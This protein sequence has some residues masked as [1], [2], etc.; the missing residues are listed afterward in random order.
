MLARMVWGAPASTRTAPATVL[1]T[2][3]VPGVPRCTA[4]TAL[5]A[6]SRGPQS[7]MTLRSKRTRCTPQPNESWTSTVWVG[8]GEEGVAPHHQSVRR[9][10]LEA[11][12][13]GGGAR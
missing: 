9:Q 11:V 1:C 2:Q 4:N 7:W 3:V 5:Q 12:H 10:H 6:G 8:T 13:V